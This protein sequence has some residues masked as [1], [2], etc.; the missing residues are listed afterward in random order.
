MKHT[1]MVTILLAAAAAP[2][3][4]MSAEP[5]AA[6]GAGAGATGGLE[7][8]VVTAERR[9]ASL[10]TVPIAV[11]ALSAETIENRQ[12][13]ACEDLQRFV[14]SLKM[15]K[16]VT[17]PTNVSPSLRGSTQQDASLVVAE[18]PFGIYVDDIYVG[19]LNGNNVSLSDIERVEVL[20]GPQGT[21]YGRNTLAGALKF[22]TRTPGDTAWFDAQVGAG[23]FDQYLASFSAGGPLSDRWAASFSGQVNNKDGQYYNVATRQDFGREHN[24]AARAKLRYMGDGIFGAVLSVSHADAS[25][26][27]TAQVPGLTPADPLARRQFESDDVVPAFGF[28]T[29]ST[30]LLTGMPAPIALQPEGTTQQTIAGLNLSW[31]L[32]GATL[33]SITGY[34]RLEDGFT[35]DFSGRGWLFAGS[36][37][38]SDQYT[39]ELQLQGSAFAERLNYIVGVYFLNETADQDFG[40]GIDLFGFLAGTPSGRIPVSTSSM[41][42]ETDSVAVF[43][44]AD[45]ALTE[46]LKLTA[47][48]RWVEDRKTFDFAFQSLLGPGIPRENIAL[49]NS[50][51]EVTPKLSLDYTIAP[52]GAVD[53]MLTYVSAARGFK[54][55]GYNGINIFDASIARTAYFPET[56]WTY[57]VGLKSELLGR[58]LRI[59][60]AAFHETVDDLTLN[61]T[62]IINGQPSFPVQNAGEA[63]IRGLELDIT[64]AATDRLTLF[65]NAAFLDGKYGQLDPTSNPA[66]APARFGISAAIPPQLPDYTVAA[67]FDYGVDVPLG[68][69]GGRLSVGA[70]VFLSAEYPVGA[71]NDQIISAYT[72]I[73]GFVALGIGENWEVR[74]SGQNLA[75]AETRYSGSRGLGGFINLPPREWLLSARYRL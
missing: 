13:R 46:A 41:Q 39:E 1:L 71:D 32:G 30:P 8:V 5:G 49:R 68:S 15:T 45:Y 69:R 53:S 21:L 4:A 19:R 31:Q 24:V 17:S 14:P 38:A 55:G 66:T 10:Q 58:R 48:A 43:G 74:V 25:N 7:E 29:T 35:A 59:N 70:D 22:Q 73:N 33:R 16:N 44:Q 11:S 26:D 60:A 37:A 23:N 20:R 64:A 50:Y 65:L 57:E 3:G 51:S 6:P 75:D 2:Q 27:A 34:V 72:R 63:T 42:I 62:T 9:E 18:S 28:Y 12:I 47:G 56:N 40:W 36:K 54:S 52:R 67:G 61:A